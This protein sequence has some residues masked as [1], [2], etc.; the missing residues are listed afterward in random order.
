MPY[1]NP[2][3]RRKL[4]PLRPTMSPSSFWA[5]LSILLCVRSSSR[6]SIGRQFWAHGCVQLTVSKNGM[7]SRSRL[8]GPTFSMLASCSFLRTC[9]PRATPSLKLRPAFKLC[10]DTAI[11]LK[12][13][14]MTTLFNMPH[15]L[16]YGCRATP[17]MWCLLKSA[18]MLPTLAIR[19][20]D[21]SAFLQRP[22]L[23]I[24]GIWRSFGCRRPDAA[25]SCD[26]R[27]IH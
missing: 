13:Y 16:S 21:V 27:Q 26:L 14:C 5:M 3:A 19:T 22:N 8:P 4:S 18:W 24:E 25:S 10:H 7:D 6:R 12:L 23:R 2:T 15:W 17:K 20:F 11:L 9:E 1:G